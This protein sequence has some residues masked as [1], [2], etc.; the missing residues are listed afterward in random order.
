VGTLHVLCGTAFSGKTTLARALER[1]FGCAV[2]S[3]DEIN[4]R[5]GLFGGQGVPDEEWARTH[6]FVLDELTALMRGG[7]PYVA[8]D[9]T[10]C[11]RF[12]RD[13]YRRLA[14][15]HGYVV[16]LLVLRPPSEEVERRRRANAGSG[17]RRGIDDEVFA[18]HV[19]SFEWPGEDEE[20]IAVPPELT[21]GEELERWLA[22]E[23]SF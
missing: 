9:D 15:E 8:V 14:A 16:R 2:V 4:E 13:D 1:C 19:A 22:A 11:F 17:E 20:P 7:A 6:G 3:A 18:A 5:R 23:R 10:A 12:L 21:A